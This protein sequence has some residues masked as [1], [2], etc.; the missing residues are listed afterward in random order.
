MVAQSIERRLDRFLLQVKNPGDTSAG[1]TTASSKIGIVPRS[2]WRS[3][4]LT[5]TTWA[6]SNLGIMNLYHQVKSAAEHARRTG[7]SPWLDMEGGDARA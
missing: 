5:F 6:M 7:F 3:P 1:N 2:K 4:S